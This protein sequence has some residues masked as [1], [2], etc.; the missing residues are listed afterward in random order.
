MSSIFYYE[1]KYD[2]C[3][4]R[5]MNKISFLNLF[6]PFCDNIEALK[7]IDYPRLIFSFIFSS[8][9]SF[10]KFSLPSQC[11]LV[12]EC[13]PMNQEVIVRFWSVH[14]PRLQAPSP[15]GGVLEVAHP[16]FSFIFGACTSILLPKSINSL[17]NFCKMYLGQ[18]H[19]LHNQQRATYS[20]NLCNYDFP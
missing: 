11:T 20:D 6:T 8:F 9:Q 14:M 2:F 10:K 17:E 18:S 12:V 16:W 15:L 7:K 4:S 13:R 1:E 19:R 3:I 5:N